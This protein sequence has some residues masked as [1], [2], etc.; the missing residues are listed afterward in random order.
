MDELDAKKLRVQKAV[1]AW[2]RLQRI[3]KYKELAADPVAW[4]KAAYESY[5]RMDE[6]HPVNKL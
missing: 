3:Q 4:R 5:K 2:K 6:K 1:R